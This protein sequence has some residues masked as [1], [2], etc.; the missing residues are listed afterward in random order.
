MASTRCTTRTAASTTASTPTARVLPPRTVPSWET[1]P[2]DDLTQKMRTEFDNSKRIHLR[3]GLAEVPG[4]D[5]VLPSRA[6]LGDGLQRRLAGGAQLQ[7]VQRPP[8][9]LPVEELLG[10]RHAGADQEDI[11]GFA[12]SAREGAHEA[13]SLISRTHRRARGP[14]GARLSYRWAWS[15]GVGV[16]RRWRRLRR[17]GRWQRVLLSRPSSSHRPSWRPC[18]ASPRLRACVCSSLRIVSGQPPRVNAG[19]GDDVAAAMYTDH[20]CP[21]PNPLPTGEET[22]LPLGVCPSAKSARGGGRTRLSVGRVSS[23]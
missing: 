12:G 20:P 6:G 16:R 9:G 5:A 4:Q 8:V 23:A 13:P 1:R 21:H 22:A 7:R 2:A 15:A 10:R 11:A 19:F 3:E 14:R 17:R 18:G